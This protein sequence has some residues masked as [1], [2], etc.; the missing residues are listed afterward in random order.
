MN[1][2]TELLTQ[3]PAVRDD[4]VSR[5][6]QAM[7]DDAQAMLQASASAGEESLTHARERLD[8]GVQKLRVRM[9]ELEDNA[10]SRLR[11]AARR[12]DGTVHTHPYAAIGAAGAAGLLLGYLLSRR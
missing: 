8:E 6:L 12:V 9:G 2:S 5:H 7:I 10:R 1:T 11:G 3:Q 4:R